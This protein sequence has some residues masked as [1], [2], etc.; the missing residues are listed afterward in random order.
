MRSRKPMLTMF[1]ALFFVFGLTAFAQQETATL[2][3][4]VKD[5]TGAVVPRATITL[6]N[7]ETNISLKTETNEQGVFFVASLKPGPYSITVEK[8][9]IQKDFAQRHHAAS[10]SGCARRPHFAGRRRHQNY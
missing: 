6:T 3:G 4:E 9:G 1:I 5:G 2:T 7:V 8:S 10:Q